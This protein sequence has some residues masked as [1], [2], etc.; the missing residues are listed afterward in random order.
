[1]QHLPS[2]SYL[3]AFIRMKYCAG[4]ISR[5]GLLSLL[6]NCTSIK[7]LFY[8]WLDSRWIMYSSR[9]QFRV[10]AITRVVLV[11]CSS[12]EYILTR[13]DNQNFNFWTA[14]LLFTKYRRLRV[15]KTRI[16]RKLHVNIV[17]AF[18]MQIML[19]LLETFLV[20]Y[21]YVLTCCTKLKKTRLKSSRRELKEHFVFFEQAVCEGVSS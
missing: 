8:K 21:Y 1:M 4:R 12:L 9:L 20:L 15:F 18:A 19:P 10:C 11:S 16:T 3:N 7:K 6:R 14:K 5:G 2:I 17:L 13:N